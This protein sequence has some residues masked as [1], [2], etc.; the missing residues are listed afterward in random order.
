MS[1]LFVSEQLPTTSEQAIREF[2]EKYLAVLSAA[3]SPTW[4]DRFK[5]G[6]GAPRVTFPISLMSTKY[7]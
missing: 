1:S 2:N 4:A 6:V 5:L 3:P 7:G